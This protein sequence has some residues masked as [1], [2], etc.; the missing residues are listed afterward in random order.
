MSQI[1]GYDHFITPTIDE[2]IEVANAGVD[3][4]ALDATDRRR[5]KNQE[6]KDL[7]AEVRNKFPQ[8]FLMSDCSTFEEGV[9]AQELGFDLIA[10][11]LSG[12]TFQTENQLLPNIE[13]IV[14]LVKNLET[15]IIA[16]GGISTY[17][18]AKDAY[19]AGAYGLVIC[20]AITRPP[21]ITKGFVEE[22][23]KYTGS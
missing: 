21:L 2:V 1:G 4:V 19:R 17:Q 16:E 23:K 22:T 13:L 14:K 12:Y 5:P 10:T 20:S 15:P 8:L 3:I 11:T 7:V 6:L 9:Y 18:D